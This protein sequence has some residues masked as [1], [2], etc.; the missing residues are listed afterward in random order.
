ME[1]GE[2]YILQ[3]KDTSLYRNGE[4][5]NYTH[6]DLPNE[7]QTMDFYLYA[8]RKG[9]PLYK[10]PLCYEIVF[11]AVKYGMSLEYVNKYMIDEKMCLQ[12]ISSNHNPS[13]KIIP[14]KFVN[15]E[16][17]VKAIELNQE[18]IKKIPKIMFT[19][20]ICD[21]VISLN[22]SLLKCIPKEFRTYEICLN[23]INSLRWKDTCISEIPFEHRQKDICKAFMEKAKNVDYAVNYIPSHLKTTEFL[24]LYAEKDGNII[25]KFPG[26]F[27][28]HQIWKLGVQSFVTR[29]IVCSNEFL[30]HC[31]KKLLSPIRKLIDEKEKKDILVQK[32]LYIFTTTKVDVEWNTYFPV[33]GSELREIEYEDPITM[34]PLQK[35]TVY[36]FYTV[37]VKKFLAGS[38][39][40]FK[41]FITMKSHNCTEENLFIPLLNK[42]MPSIDLEWVVW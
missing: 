16:F 17:I 21:Y 29:N 3:L 39:D 18:F 38:V 1:L 41:M 9:V 42:N 10:L 28:S 12:Y 14:S 13:L 2:H 31:P 27:W 5:C 11:E 37:G 30:E 36:A 15:E 35:G 20:K 8:V 22:G 19:Q 4:Y 23:A 26:K 6:L 33:A 32:L 40:M 7:F 24:K 34:E 25:P